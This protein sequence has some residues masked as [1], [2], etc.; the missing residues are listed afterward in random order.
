[1]SFTD[2]HTHLYLEQFIND[3]DS[4]IE[5]AILNDV[6]R[7]FFPAISSKYSESMFR[8]KEKYPENIFLMSGLHPCYVDINFSDEIKHVEMIINEK[9]IVAVGEI[10]IDLYWD[11]SNL[12]VQIKA[13]ESQITIANNYNLP[14][15]IHCRESFDEI[16]AVLAKNKIINGGIFHCFSG[17]LNQAKKIIDLGM[18]LGIGGVVTFKNGKIDN[19]LNQIDITNIVL[20]TDS[21]YLSPSP[22][23]GKRNESS[24]IKYIAEKLCNI[25]DL[26]IQEIA[27]I[28]T[29]NSKDV[30]G[31]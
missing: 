17:D 14:I 15:V 8:L 5:N 20:E 10:G 18:K 11:K 3:V 24:N 13:F 25:Y 23:R 2:T 7:L 12:D 31:I 9:E 29:Q 16:Y 21:P 27:D 19:F 6:N 30:F 4:V 26:S 22:M 1:M 28:T